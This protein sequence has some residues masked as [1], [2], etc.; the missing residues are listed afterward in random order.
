MSSQR[1]ELQ[2]SF[3]GKAPNKVKGSGG[4]RERLC[5]DGFHYGGMSSPACAASLWAFTLL[6]WLI[7]TRSEFTFLRTVVIII[8]A[9]FSVFLPESS[10]VLCLTALC[11]VE[12]RPDRTNPPRRLWPSCLWRVQLRSSHRPKVW[13]GSNLSHIPVTIN[14][15][16]TVVLHSRG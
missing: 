11:V 9:V 14:F 16:I 13:V 4:L 5:H 1:A 7:W 3:S 6:C 2:S 15:K 12:R 10:A 8:V